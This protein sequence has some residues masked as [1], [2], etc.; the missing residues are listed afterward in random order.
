MSGARQQDGIDL[1]RYVRQALR[2]K[3]LLLAVIVLIPA[4][5]YGLTK[6]QPK[7]Y[8]ASTLLKVAPQNIS[9]SN[10]ITF[11]TSGAAETARIIKTTAVAKV[12]AQKLGES[13]ASAGALLGKITAS[14]SDTTD[15]SFL[16]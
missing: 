11:G 3:W 16:T 13:P 10:T 5:A 12:A 15:T 7:V 1:R 8:Q 6:R 2:R 4:A 9:V 14:G